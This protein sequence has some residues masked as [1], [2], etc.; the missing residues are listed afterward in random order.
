MVQNWIYESKEKS[1]FDVAQ[2][3]LVT[4]VDCL[5]LKEGRRVV[6][7]ACDQVSTDFVV[8]KFWYKNLALRGIMSLD[9]KFCL[10]G[11]PRRRH[12]EDV[13]EVITFAQKTSIF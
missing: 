8:E 6:G 3:V 1:G 7:E 12:P 10:P 11:Y 13:L 4:M 5:V 2:D 9:R